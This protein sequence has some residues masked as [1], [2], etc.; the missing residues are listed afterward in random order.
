[1][2]IHSVFR[3]HLNTSD[4]GKMLSHLKKTIDSYFNSTSVHGFQYVKSGNHWLLRLI[5]VSH[6][7]YKTSKNSCDLE[8]K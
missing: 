7:H 1:M 4:H 2:D 8:L 6:V 3:Q 5:W